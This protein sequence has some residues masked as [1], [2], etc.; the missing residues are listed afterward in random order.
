MKQSIPLLMA[1]LVAMSCGDAKETTSSCGNA[2]YTFCAGDEVYACNS[3][4]QI[5]LVK[6]CGAGDCGDGACKS[7]GLGGKEHD[8]FDHAGNPGRSHKCKDVSECWPGAICENGFCADKNTSATCKSDNDC[9]NDQWCQSGECQSMHTGASNG[10]QSD[11]E[12][13]PTQICDWKNECCDKVNKNQDCS[14]GLECPTSTCYVVGKIECE[15]DKDC[16]GNRICYS[17]VCYKGGVTYTE[18]AGPLYKSRC[19]WCHGE[20]VQEADWRWD[21]YES[22][23]QPA[24]T[25]PGKSVAECTVMRIKNGTLPTGGDGEDNDVSD[26]ELGLLSA[27]VAGGMKK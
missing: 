3:D 24:K 13:S 17:N 12:C 19:S 14:D 16:G 26:A 20:F 18:H 23:T 5:S 9:L 8:D 15:T 25:C 27:W 21:S 22:L 6:T 7:D 10:C 4:G 2:Y 1:C 11:S